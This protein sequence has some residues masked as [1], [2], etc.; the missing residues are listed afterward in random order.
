MRNPRAAPCR[1]CGPKRRARGAEA[2]AG[3]VARGSRQ[4]AAEERGGKRGCPSARLLFRQ[5]RLRRWRCPRVALTAM[6]E[7]RAAAS[8]DAGE[9]RRVLTRRLLARL[10]RGVLCAALRAASARRPRAPRPRRACDRARQP[11][12]CGAPRGAL[13]AALPAPSSVPSDARCCLAAPRLTAASASSPRPG[14]SW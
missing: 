10:A 14:R 4:H 13:A 6:A 8:T 11:A 2:E 7:R 9:C 5:A 1:R 3:S 12:G